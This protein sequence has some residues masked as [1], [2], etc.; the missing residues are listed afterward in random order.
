MPELNIIGAKEKNRYFPYQGALRVTR[1]S[2][3]TAGQDSYTLPPAKNP[4]LFQLM[5]NVEPVNRGILQRRRGYQLLSTQ[6]PSIPYREGYS[7][8]SESLNLKS[9]VWTSTGNVLALTE[10]GLTQLATIFTPSLAAAFAPR[11]V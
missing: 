11:M 1:K 9:V 10:P 2:F 6:A 3:W 8:R 4:D 5:T 7:F